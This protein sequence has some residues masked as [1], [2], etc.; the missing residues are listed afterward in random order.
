ML[1]QRVAVLI[2]GSLLLAPLQAGG[3]PRSL[4]AL[5]QDAAF[6]GAFAQLADSAGS[7]RQ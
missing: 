3:R 1:L 5:R 7:R 4:P 2:A 6:G